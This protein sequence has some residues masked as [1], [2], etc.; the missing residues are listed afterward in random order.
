MTTARWKPAG[1]ILVGA[2]AGLFAL[3]SGL[4]LL[5]R[6]TDPASDLE[7][8]PI[9]ALTFI[10]SAV[11]ASPIA[12]RWTFVSCALAWMANPIYLFASDYCGGDALC[13]VSVL[14]PHAVGLFAAGAISWRYRRSHRRTVDQTPQPQVPS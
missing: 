11:V 12:K 1:R 2:L 4:L 14:S 6:V 3:V 13:L 8:I 7:A 5:L 10:L 9:I